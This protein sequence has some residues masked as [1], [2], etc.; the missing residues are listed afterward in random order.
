M[1]SKAGDA[2]YRRN[3]AAGEVLGCAGGRERN[4]NFSRK[5]DVC[6]VKRVAQ[7]QHRFCVALK[8]DITGEEQGVAII[9]AMEHAQQCRERPSDARIPRTRVL[10]A[11]RLDH[12]SIRMRPEPKNERQINRVDQKNL[13]GVSLKPRKQGGLLP[14]HTLRGPLQNQ[15]QRP[16]WQRPQKQRERRR[17]DRKTGRIM[18]SKT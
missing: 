5:I 9:G 8:H 17:D 3:D 13:L 11:P 10:A 14:S 16:Q 6:V 1:R 15:T 4:S 18:H 7:R 2:E 12:G